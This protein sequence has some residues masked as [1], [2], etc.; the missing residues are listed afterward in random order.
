MRVLAVL[1]SKMLLVKV[2]RPVVSMVRRSVN[3]PVLLVVLLPAVVVLRTRAPPQ[4]CFASCAM[5][6]GSQFQSVAV[7]CG[8]YDT[9]LITHSLSW[10]RH[11]PGCCSQKSKLDK[12][13][14]LL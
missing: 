3:W 7:C 5:Q 1:L 2:A 8:S 9:R 13:L 11:T 6:Q 14:H 10:V 12:L 4:L